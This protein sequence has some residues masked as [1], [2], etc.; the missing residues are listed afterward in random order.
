[1]ANYPKPRK[2][3]DAQKARRRLV[4]VA[5]VLFTIGALLWV[6]SLYLAGKPGAA[7]LANALRVP[8]PWCFFIGALLVILYTVVGRRQPAANAP[9]RDAMEFGQ[10]TT[11]FHAPPL[12]EFGPRDEPRDEPRNEQRND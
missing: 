6:A 9:K 10:S 3:L 8:A 7:A 1:L 4:E 11:T 2:P 5:F 12:D